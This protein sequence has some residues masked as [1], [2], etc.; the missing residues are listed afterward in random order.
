M[1]QLGLTERELRAWRTSFRMLELLRMRVEQQ[2]QSSSGLSNADYTVL[3]VLSEAPEGRMRVYELGRVAGWEKSRMHHQLTRMSGRGLITRERC[4]SRG[5]HAVITAKG[6]ATLKDAV[7]GHAREVRRLFV[8]RLTPEEL[9]QFA[10]TAAKI[11]DNLQADQ[12]PA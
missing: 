5:M 2:L 8:D 4:G 11:L 3:A 6:L 9:D 12:S 1:A 7:P 10:D